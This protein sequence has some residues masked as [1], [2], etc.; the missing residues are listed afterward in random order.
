LI[1]LGVKLRVANMPSLTPETPDGFFMF[2]IQMGLDQREVDVLRQR[3]SDGME[4]KLRAGGWPNKAPE[5]YLNKERPLKSNKYERWVELDPKQGP[6]L[7]E[8]WDLLLTKR[9]TLDQICEELTKR[10]HTR[11]EQRPWAWKDPKT[12]RRRTAKN[13]LH[14]IFH[15]AF[16]AFCLSAKSCRHGN[17]M[18]RLYKRT[19]PSVKLGSECQDLTGFHLCRHLVLWGKNLSGLLGRGAAR[20]KLT[21][22]STWSKVIPRRNTLPQRR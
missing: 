22:G 2:L 8:A 18:G 21:I 5:G 3:T 16:Y 9:Y 7:R 17:M 20:Q 10:G 19:D 13:R 14:E 11:S 12:G 6:V 15:N 1:G 4:A